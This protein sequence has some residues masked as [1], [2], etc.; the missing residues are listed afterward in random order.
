MQFPRAS[1]VLLHLTALPGP[2]GS[3]DLGPSA[4][5]FVDWLVAGG[6][7]LW[8][9]LPLGGI[10]LGNS[11]YMSSSAFAGNPLLIDLA[12]LQRQGW[13]DGDGLPADTRLNDESIDFEAVIAYRMQALGCAAAGF[14]ARASA[15]DRQD[16]EAFCL[17]QATWLDDYALF[18]ALQAQHPNLPWN[19][20]PQPLAQREASALAQASVALVGACQF[21][22]FC[23]WVFF[24]QWRAFKAYANG[25]GVRIIGDIPIFIAH[26]SAEVWARPDLFELD[27]AGHP[28]VVAGVPPDGFSV[29]GQRWG[30]PLYRWSAHGA[31]QYRWWIARIAGTCALVDLVRLDHFRGFESYW[32]IPASAPTAVQGRWVPAPGDALLRAVA[33]ALGTLPIIAEDLG[34]ITPGVDALR[35]RHGLP[36]MR[37]LQFAFGD[38]QDASSRYLPHNYTAD[39][40]VYTGTHDN[41]TTE[42]WWH[43]LSDPTRQHVRE[44][45]GADGQGMAWAL[46]RAACASVADMAIYPMQDVLGLDG[47]HRMNQP[48]VGEGNWV[49]RFTWAQVGPEPAQRLH[50][51]ARLYDR[52]PRPPGESHAAA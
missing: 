38:D 9:M 27:A 19:Q 17:A 3:G 29:T 42:G 50:H 49:W 26:Q 10:G 37:V 48:G 41:D 12:E 46:I 1:G 22:R 45:L 16:F 52:L 32:E 51:L 2:H 21:W 15:A 40:V 30:N 5:H 35:Q 24:R 23:Q 34:V 4:Y 7:S 33:E 36:G 28:T 18:M 20:W 8:Q 31:E 14:E 39:S 43:T 25:R 47:A 6:Q 11:P 44:Y 13:L